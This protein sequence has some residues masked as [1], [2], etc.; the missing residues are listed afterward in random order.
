MNDLSS[1]QKQIIKHLNDYLQQLGLNI[2][3]SKESEKILQF[4]R[5]N[6]RK[7]TS[8]ECTENAYLLYQY[9]IFIQREL[10]KHKSLQMWAIRLLDK[11]LGVVLPQQGNKYTKFEEKRLLA[12]NSG[13]NYIEEL[14]KLIREYGLYIDNLYN[15]TRYIEKMASTLEQLSWEKKQQLKSS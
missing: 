12:L 7:L 5:D 3:K 15:L 4:N 13:N 14:D 9:A 8:E 2:S 6:L 1:R 10:N 11:E